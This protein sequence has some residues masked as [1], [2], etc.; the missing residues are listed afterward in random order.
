MKLIQTMLLLVIFWISL[1]FYCVSFGWK[2]LRHIFMRKKDVGIFRIHTWV[3]TLDGR[4]GITK[5]VWMPPPGTLFLTLRFQGVARG[6]LQSLG[7]WSIATWFLPTDVVVRRQAC[8]C[9]FYFLGGRKGCGEDVRPFPFPPWKFWCWF[10]WWF[11][12]NN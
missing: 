5:C 8:E 1:N 7:C 2:V 3:A 6:A 11:P 12:L 9:E 10:W 4:R